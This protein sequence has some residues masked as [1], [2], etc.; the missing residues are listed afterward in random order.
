MEK[1]DPENPPE[2]V[3]KPRRKTL[4][5]ITSG[6]IVWLQKNSPVT[7]LRLSWD[8]AMIV[9]NVSSKLATCT[10][11]SEDGYVYEATIPVKYLKRCAT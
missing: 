7:P 11:R 4:P 1:H 9:G 5:A 2:K 3:K 10:W 6:D 8:R